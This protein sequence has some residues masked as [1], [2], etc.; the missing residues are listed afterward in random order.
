[1]RITGLVR[2]MQYYHLS[3]K[4]A[5]LLIGIVL[6][7]STM[8][9]HDIGVYET[10]M[11][12]AMLLSFFWVESVVKGYLSIYNEWSQ[13]QQDK[14][15]FTLY[16]T[17]LIISAALCLLFLWFKPTVLSWLTG[18]STLKY[19]GWLILYLF[20][21]QPSTITVYILQLKEKGREIYLFSTVHAAGLFLGVA[22]PVILGYSLE[23]AMYGLISFAVIMHVYSIFMLQKWWS[24]SFDKRILNR[25][26]LI[27]SPLIF[28]AIVQSFAGVFD[29]WLV[30]VFYQD[31][32]SFAIFRFGARELPLVVPLAVGVSNLALPLLT[33]S[34]D[35]GL[36]LLRIESA[37]LMHLLFPIALLLMI[38]SYPLFELIYNTSFRSSAA[39]FNVYLL[40]I[41]PQLWFPQTIFLA[42]K[43][44][45]ILVYIGI[46]EV[47][48]NVILS[49]LLISKL[50]MVGIAIGTFLAYVIEKVILILV[51]RRR[52]AVEPAR[53]LPLKWIIFY[54][55][56]IILVYGLVGNYQGFL[57]EY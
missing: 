10:L 6:A 49:L 9:L 4:G 7:K 45:S 14:S 51:A 46:I 38:F 17:F 26:L 3:R 34:R 55:I 15:I 5:V 21:Y 25:L 8:S 29:A 41:I 24:F 39:I 16:M 27:S 32:E 57:V 20:L 12:I 22:L 53:Y 42:R 36:S 13:R 1:M 50:G 19:V 54:G 30:N 48:L 2:S 23:G 33:I 44:N 52:H 31:K 11:F 40:L 43:D 18:E 56:L 37:R 28:Y 35:K 47:A